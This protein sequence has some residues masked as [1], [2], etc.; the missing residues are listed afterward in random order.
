MKLKLTKEYRSLKNPRSSRSAVFLWLTVL[1]AMGA[2]ETQAL[3]CGN[4]QPNDSNVECVSSSDTEDVTVSVQN[5]TNITTTDSHGISGILNNSAH[6]RSNA[7]G[8]TVTNTTITT[9][10]TDSAGYHGIYGSQNGSTG[11]L[12][13]TATDT[14]ITTNDDHSHGINAEGTANHTGNINIEAIGSNITTNAEDAYGIN[15]QHQGMSGN[16][17][18]TA[19]DTTITTNDRLS[20]GIH[21]W[22]LDPDNDSDIGVTINLRNVHITTEGTRTLFGDTSSHGVFVEHEGSGGDIVINAHAGTTI[23]T[24]G[25]FSTGLFGKHEGIDDIR[26]NVHKGASIMTQGEFAYG[27]Y[28]DHRASGDVHIITAPGSSITTTGTSSHGIVAHQRSTTDPGAIDITVGGKITT[29]GDAQGVS[30]GSISSG[31]AARVAAI[32]EDGYRQQTV[33][34]NGA[35]KS[36]AEGVFLAGGGRVAIGPRGSIIS[37]SG[38][39]ILA[40]GNTRGAN[41]ND[42]DITPKLRVDMNLG[43]RRVAEAIGEA[44]GDGSIINDGGETTIA[45]NGTVLHNGETGVVT[46]AMVHNGV[47]DVRM[48]EKGVNVSDYADPDPANWTITAP[49]VG[50]VIGRDFSTEDFIEEYAPR[51]AVY[52]VLSDFL[53]RL[54][55]PGSS[56]KCR[57]APEERGWIRYSGGK[58]SYEADRTT[59]GVIYDLER[60]EAEGGVSTSFNDK[61]RGW[62]SV[63]HDSGSADVMSPTGG[64]AINARGLG[65]SVGGAWQSAT[66]VYAIGCFSYITYDVDFTTHQVGL[67]RAGVKSRAYTLD[68]ETGRRFP[69]TGQW[70]LTPRFRVVGSR[71]S[72]DS[73][74]D[75]VEA[76]VSSVR[77]NRNLGGLGIVA[78]TTRPWRAGELV[79]SGSM[80]VERLLSGADTRVQVSGE[81]LSAAAM[82]NSLLIGLNGAYH[83]DRFTAGV[84]VVAQHE[85]GSGNINYASFLSLGIRF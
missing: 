66:G 57:T 80:D 54:T 38:I 44:I 70:H 82:K 24:K 20:S 49:A 60:F 73:F 45:V 31:Y 7:V 46:D 77:A 28:G 74:T 17:D 6:N 13:I 4:P 19:T 58:G 32:G 30:V 76:R 23:N 52:E 29:S 15:V 65:A 3:E 35:V 56:R 25:T 69:L 62:A 5:V 21:A 59:T 85:L 68:M 34:V 72:V 55:G 33:T 63:R 39:S 81:Q 53:L 37:E 64:G 83:Q 71:V 18:I 12:D 50:V 9:N 16:I 51:A 2:G 78:D 10:S 48:R 41:S 84:E 61:A 67:L 11:H 36:N 43:D 42:P 27:L 26:I 75:A 47:W 22:V 8:I 79:L 14:T 1:L 40:T